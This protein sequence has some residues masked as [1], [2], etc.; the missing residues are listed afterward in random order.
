VTEATRKEAEE[1]ARREVSAFSISVLGYD[2]DKP[3]NDPKPEELLQWVR[4]R[5]ERSEK[6]AKW[7]G[8]VVLAAAA[9]IGTAIL[10]KITPIVVRY[11]GL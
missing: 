4:Q 1:I 10:S 5:R 11:L 3:G 2:R 8:S 9:A 7:L 6:M